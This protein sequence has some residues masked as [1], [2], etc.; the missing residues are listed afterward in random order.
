[1]KESYKEG[2]WHHFAPES[3]QGGPRGRVEAFTGESKIKGGDKTRAGF[4]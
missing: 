4:F 1:M 3:C 2:D